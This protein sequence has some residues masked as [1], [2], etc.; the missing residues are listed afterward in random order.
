MPAIDNRALSSNP[1]CWWG[2]GY[3]NLDQNLYPDL[4]L[5]K[6]T[7]WSRKLHLDQDILKSLSTAKKVGAVVQSPIDFNQLIRNL[8]SAQRHE[9]ICLFYH[10]R[11]YWKRAANLIMYAATLIFCALLLRAI[12]HQVYPINASPKILPTLSWMNFMTNFSHSQHIQEYWASDTLGV[13]LY[14]N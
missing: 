9:D 11:P 5:S 1:M 3:F 2:S 14:F 6:S 8:K 12:C 7:S 4:Y 10:F 13:W